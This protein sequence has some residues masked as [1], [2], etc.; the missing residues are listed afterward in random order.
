MARIQK[1]QTRSGSPTYIVKWRTPD[2]RDRSK[3]GFRTRK[4]ALAYATTAEATRLRGATFDPQAGN[5]TFR[6]A[7]QAWLASRHD[8]KPITFAEHRCALAHTNTV[9]GTARC[10]ALM[11]VSVATRSMPLPA[12]RFQHGSRR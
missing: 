4:A 11:R 5:T 12:N 3:G 7:A 2:G 10:L 8:L 9:A 1:R 6:V